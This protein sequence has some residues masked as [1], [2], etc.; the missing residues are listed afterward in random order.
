MRVAAYRARGLPRARANHETGEVPMTD[1]E[2][3]LASLRALETAVKSRPP[4]P[5]VR[6]V[7]PPRYAGPTG[8]RR[9]KDEDGVMHEESGAE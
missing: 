6:V 2:R 8:P 1:K 7:P 4:A 3:T 5:P 9:W